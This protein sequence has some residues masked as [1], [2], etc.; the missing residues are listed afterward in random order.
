VSKAVL[1]TL[2]ERFGAA[3]LE[4]HSL[5]GDDTAVVE[6]SRWREIAQFLRSDPRMAF[7]LFVDLFEVVLHLRSIEHG[8]RIRLKTRV[9]DAEGDGA[10]LQ[11]L[12]PVWPGANWFE[13][14]TYD[15][16]G[17]TFTGHPDLRRILLYEE[18]V[19]H[20]LRKDYPANKAQPLVELRDLPDKMPPFGPDMGMSFGRQTHEYHRDDP[21]SVQEKQRIAR[22]AAELRAQG[23]QGLRPARSGSSQSSAADELDEEI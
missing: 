19:G 20:P 15:L 10:V 14:E 4:T 18:F 5:L 6:P 16:M 23:V 21:L 8:H 11:S 7:N 1:D 13:R 9:G 3:I 22:H 2:Q 12:V 17:V